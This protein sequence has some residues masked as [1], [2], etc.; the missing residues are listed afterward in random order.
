MFTIQSKAEVLS[1][2]HD[3]PSGKRIE[4]KAISLGII[5]ADRHTQK[6]VISLYEKSG[7]CQTIGVLG[8]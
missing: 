8:V 1:H 3:L 7:E 4:F 5:E 2:R 6:E